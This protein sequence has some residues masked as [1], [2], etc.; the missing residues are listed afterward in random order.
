MIVRK[1]QLW[2]VA[3]PGGDCPPAVVRHS[4]KSPPVPQTLQLRNFPLSTEQAT[5]AQAAKHFLT[6]DPITPLLFRMA[7]PTIAV[8]LIQGVVSTAEV[9]FVGRLGSEAI[10]GVALCFPVLMLMMALSAAGFGSGISSAVARA[11]GGGRTAHAQALVFDSLVLSL[12]IGIFFTIVMHFAG[13]VLYRMMGGEGA[14]LE[15]AVLYS[16]VFFN[17]AIL[18]WIFNGLTSI[19]RGCGSMSYPAIVG[20]CGGAVT[21]VASPTLIFGWGPFPAMG[22][23]GAGLAVVSFYAIGIVVLLLR[24]FS[25]KSPLKPDIAQWKFDGA[26]TLD[27]LKVALPSSI[28][29]VI[30]SGNAMIM[31]GLVGPFGSIALAGFGLA[32]RLEYILMP[33]IFGLGTA[34]ITI[35][36]ANIGAGQVDRAKEATWRGSVF[37]SAFTGILGIILTLFPGLWLHIF[38]SDPAVIEI[39]AHYFHRVGPIYVCFGAGMICY[40]AAQGMGRASL[41]MWI[42]IARLILVA[43]AGIWAGK[44]WGVEGVFL[45]MACGYVMFGA[46]LSAS[47]YRLFKTWDA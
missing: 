30:S 11:I 32:T 23:V 36:G 16:S 7:A 19:F 40:A 35:V 4:A 26:G 5:S 8:M 10:A 9:Y 42:A 47:L 20:A 34:V 22:I 15:N 46:G 13:P 39:G 45:A 37:A 3:D 31:T 41:P 43:P 29:S 28:N 17:G 25:S 33:I 38:S 27:I 21:I 6:R 24:L 2:S 44:H 12:V 18:L 14:T 1:L